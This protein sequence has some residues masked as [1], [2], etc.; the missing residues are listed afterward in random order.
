MALR[1]IDGFSHYTIPAQ[2]PLKYSTCSTGY[3][4]SVTGRRSGTTAMKMY[5][6]ADFVAMTFDDQST[7][8]VGF[9][10]YATASVNSD[11]K[12]LRFYDSSGN[13]QLTLDVVA[14]LIKLYSGNVSTLLATASQTIP[15][16][17]WVYIE[18]KVII[19][20]TGGLFEVRVNETVVASYTGDTKYSSTLST[21]RT[22]RLGSLYLTNCWFQD[23]YICDGTGST[24]NNYLGDVRI[25][26]LLPVA[27]GASAQ[28]TPT[29]NT[30]NWSNVSDTAIDTDTTYNAG[31]TAGYIDTFDCANLSSTNATI[32]GAQLNVAARKDD[33]GT[34][35][36]HGVMRVNGTNYESADIALSTSYMVYRQIQELNPNT[37]TAWTEAIINGAEFGYKVQA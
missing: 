9:A 4:T 25:D 35:T 29:G 24:N 32:Y 26:A 28:F 12:I 34:R 13:V 20:D 31:D 3:I 21:A 16:G 7:W 22:I 19:A 18:A 8:I 10:F 17:S 36:L 2:T 5:A 1:F 30:T 15:V 11:S 33:S 27:A 37:S 23:L 6:D 14:G